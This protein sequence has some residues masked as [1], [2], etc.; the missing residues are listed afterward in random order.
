MRHPKALKEHARGLLSR[1]TLSL[2]EHV[3][4]HIRVFHAYII[5]PRAR[6]FNYQERA[7]DTYA[8]STSHPN[9]ILP[10]ARG[11]SARLRHSRREHGTSFCLLSA[12]F[13]EV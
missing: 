6:V 5:S 1:A 8:A 3:K 10:R 9:M 12:I 2:C 4:G 13:P 11:K 7:R